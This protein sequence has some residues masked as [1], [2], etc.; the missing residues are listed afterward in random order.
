MARMFICF[1]MSALVLIGANP[2]LAQTSSPKDEKV[3]VDLGDQAISA[4]ETSASQSERLATFE[5]LLNNNFDMDR[6]G[7]FVL[8]RYWNVATEAERERYIPLFKDMIVK[9]YSKRFSDYS[10]QKFKVNGS[11]VI[12][13]GDIIVNSSIL[14]PVGK[15][16]VSV[17]WRLRDGKIIDVIVEGV[18]MSV[19]QRSEFN[20]I[21]Q[22]NGGKVS[23]LINHLEKY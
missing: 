16:P 18:S 12:G 20:S 9:V 8:G 14:S 10:G 11:K 17:D 5:R 1:L 21:I 23:A 7:R 22:R 19:T 4:L 2:V 13:R 3:I 15:P 6:I